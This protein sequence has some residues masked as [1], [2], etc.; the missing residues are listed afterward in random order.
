MG[1]LGNQVVKFF[2]GNNSIAIGITPFN[3]LLKHGV[4]SEFTEVLGNLP[5]V[6]QCDESCISS[7]LPVFWAS[8]VMKTL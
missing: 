7:S 1:L 6:L 5:E 2:L 3:H 8:K 4:I